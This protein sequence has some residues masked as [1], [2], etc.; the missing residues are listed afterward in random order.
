MVYEHAHQVAPPDEINPHED[1][2]YERSPGDAPPQAVAQRHA[3]AR[4]DE[5]SRERLGGVGEA[6]VHV[7]KEREE[8][9]QQGVHGQQRGVVHACRR[10]GEE[11]VDRDD[12]ERAQDDVAVD[13]EERLQRFEVQHLRPV[14]PG[15]D[16][17]VFGGE[18][19]RRERHAGPLG[20]HRGV[21]DAHDAHIHPEGE[22]EAAKDVHDVD[23]DGRQHGEY[24]VLHPREPAVEPEEHDARRHGPD[25]GVEVVAGHFAA[26]HGPE[27]Q[28]SHGVLEQDH[29][30]THHRRHRQRAGQHVGALAEVARA[31]RLGRQPAGSHAHERAVPVN[32]VEDRDADGQRAD[33]GGGVGSPVSGDGGRYDAHER[34]GDVRDDIG[35]RNAQ[36]FA[37]HVHNAGSGVAA[38]A[39]R[40]GASAGMPPVVGELFFGKDTAKAGVL[41]PSGAIIPKTVE[42]GH[43]MCYNPEKWITFA[44]WK[45][46]RTGCVR[47][48]ARE[49]G[50]HVPVP[51]PDN[52][53]DE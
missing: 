6:V 41:S 29:Q 21:G 12:A 2:R 40:R 39:G 49:P 4:A 45:P 5:T 32:E 11:G 13:D 15:E 16:R 17:T 53:L 18:Q 42:I 47:Y 36:Y 34:H 14:D 23:R 28:F 9:Q 30:H 31:E 20:D 27:G 10:P 48:H 52:L 43:V 22:P 1:H 24:G 3:V 19:Q 7:G 50:R 46:A 35:E 51:A 38:D 37:V 33:R 44:G 25:A 26:V 8:L